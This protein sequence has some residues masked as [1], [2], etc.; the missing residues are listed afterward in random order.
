MSIHVAQGALLGTVCVQCTE[1]VIG[2]RNLYTYNYT[3][4]C[5]LVILHSLSQVAKSMG[6]GHTVVTCL[7]D[8]GQVGVHLL[9]LS[10]I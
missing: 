3:C 7:C 10:S 4:T 9:S 8:S 6:P 1:Y 5:M 2:C